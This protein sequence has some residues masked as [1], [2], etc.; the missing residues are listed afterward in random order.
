RTVSYGQWL[1]LRG[2][3]CRNKRPERISRQSNWQQRK[4]WPS[5]LA[6]AFLVQL[7][8]YGTSIQRIAFTMPVLELGHATVAGFCGFNAVPTLWKTI[9]SRNRSIA[10][11]DRLQVPYDLTGGEPTDAF[12]LINCHIWS[13]EQLISRYVTVGACCCCWG[14]TSGASS[15]PIG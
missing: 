11:S 10:A 7:S 3:W 6:F 1:W 2:Y 13:W 4:S 14:S 5:M 9:S 15:R 8:G 12:K